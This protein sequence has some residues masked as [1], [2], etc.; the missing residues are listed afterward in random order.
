MESEE[1][2]GEIVEV[3]V[4][5]APTRLAKLS[6]GGVV[7]EQATLANAQVAMSILEGLWDE[8]SPEEKEE[9][10]REIFDLQKPGN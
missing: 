2:E 4:I 5:P 8:L 1:P 9:H 7:L 3:E 10:L 6:W